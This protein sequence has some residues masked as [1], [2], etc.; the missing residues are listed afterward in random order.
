MLC[1]ADRIENN[2]I[3]MNLRPTEARHHSA[4]SN[5]AT[6]VAE[7]LPVGESEEEA[8]EVQSISDDFF[9]EDDM[10]FIAVS[11]DYQNRLHEPFLPTPTE[12]A[13]ETRGEQMAR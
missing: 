4:S 11:S 3:W 13:W 1:L 6:K 7:P 9:F 12:S 8:P 10:D 2:P 5:E